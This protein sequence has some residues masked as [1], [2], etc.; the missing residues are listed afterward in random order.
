MPSSTTVSDPDLPL[1]TLLP[2]RAL[3]ITLE[4]I[5]PSRPDFFHQP[6]L[7]AF[8][9]YL[10]DSPDDYELCIRIDTPETGHIYYQS[11]D[12]YR[13]LLIG[14]NGSDE[15][16]D[17]LLEQLSKLPHSATET[18]SSGKHKAFY[19]N[20]RLYSIQDALTAEPVQQLTD[21][22]TY[23]LDT[24]NQEVELWRSE[25][26]FHW[27]WLSP[28]RLLKDKQQREALKGEARFCRDAGDISASLLFNRLHDN[29]AD[30]LR[31]RG[32]AGGQR[33][34]PPQ[35]SIP[36]QHL[37]WLDIVYSATNK[38][39]GGVSGVIEL[40][41][42]QPLSVTWWKLLILGQY[43]GIGQ[44]TS[45]GWGRYQLVNSQGGSSYRRP[46]PAASLLALA[47]DEDNLSKAW[48]HVMSGADVDFHTGDQGA[49]DEDD[50]AGESSELPLKRLRKD[51]QHLQRGEYSFPLLRGYLL[52]KPN[53]GVRPLAVP[54]V[55]DRVLQRSLQQVLSPALERL[56]YRHSHGF[57]PGRSRIS[58]R[59]DIQAAWRAGYRWVYESDIK[60]FFDSVN[61]QRLQQRLWGIYGDDPVIGAILGWMRADVRFN[62]EIVKRNHG[63]PQGSPLSPLMANLL[64]D[65]FDSDME[66]AGFH[67]IRFADDF[68]VL[69]KDP[70]Q[71]K[72]AEQAALKSLQEHG[73]DL[74]PDK[75]RITTMD[76]GFKYLGYLFV[77]DMALDISG[78]NKQSG[79]AATMSP[80]SW[81]SQLGEQAPERLSQSDVLARMA[82]QLGQDQHINI[83]ER[84]K[85]KTLLAITGEPCVLSTLNQRL[86][87]HRKDK[88]LYYLPW[89]HLS[90]VI[91]LGNHQITTQ[92]MQVAMQK[93]VTIHLAMGSGSYRGSISTHQGRQG[94]QLWLQQLLVFK[95]ADKALYCA[96]EIVASRLRHMKET[97]RQRALGGQ[98]PVL[99]RAI[100]NLSQTDNL[101]SL[102]GVEG[103]A[104]R[105][106][107][108]LLATLV[109]EAFGFNGR[110]RRP[111]RDPFNVLLSLG[112]TV[113]YGYVESIVQV[114]GLLPQMGFYHQGRGQHAALASD[115][116]EPFRHLVERT[117]LTV[118]LR[119]EL[120][121]D[122]FS[123]TPAGACLM[124]N[125]A[126]RKYLALLL[127]NWESSVRAKGETDSEKYFTHLHRQTLSLRDFIRNGDVF[128]AWRL[129]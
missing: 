21:S 23:S 13:F 110:N 17:R 24:L 111:P 58:A 96:R 52:P 113:L 57:R 125:P 87:V 2:I 108:S 55:Y 9:R 95:D 12:Y 120:S 46:L 83:G 19:D 90:A 70:E 68:I 67:L 92:A 86:Q 62:G 100:K 1:Y 106:Y 10:A 76:E 118:L 65:D 127:H 69:C 48:R 79:K 77:N 51:L 81:V 114:T 27:Q 78:G 40:H 36:D 119:K 75:T 49:E 3:V 47:A 129:R 56:M 104:T 85:H 97:L 42:A 50:Q 123:Q 74:H 105:E 107:F 54:P 38:P 89:N 71:A 39:M 102:R 15:I 64:L 18:E 103:S 44:R 93:H 122:D 91:L 72:A 53:G 124:S 84:D 33:G 117:A 61:L 80:N 116:M 30:L 25:Q 101:A 37:F 73:L 94:H 41:S 43:L 6:A 28:A 99:D 29:L 26:Q 35:L 59:Y 31:R 34:Q 32:A 45:F 60:N 63:L 7:T 98:A 14:L 22:S 109:P 128:K 66:Q 121:M 126:R 115:L 4:F 112:Y 5:R 11:G 88:R 8:L 16:L 82:R 20:L